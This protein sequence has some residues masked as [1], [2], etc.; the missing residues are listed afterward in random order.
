ML[1]ANIGEGDGG[2]TGLSVD[3]ARDQAGH[4]HG[5]YRRA[6]V[7]REGVVAPGSDTAGHLQVNG[8]VEAFVA[9]DQLRQHGFPA[10]ICKRIADTDRVQAVL[11]S[12][13]V[14]SESKQFAAIDGNDLIH[15]VAEQKTAIHDRDMGLVQRQKD[16]VQK[17]G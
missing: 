16:A 10:V 4:A 6:A 9:G 12:P 14:R 17:G 7:H 11:Q 1:P 13:Q 15:T 3:V 5:E 8:L 2:H